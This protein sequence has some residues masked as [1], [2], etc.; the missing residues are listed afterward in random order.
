MHIQTKLLQKKFKNIFDNI[1]D[2]YVQI[3][4]DAFIDHMWWWWILFPEWK[5]ISPYYE[6]AYIIAS[7][8]IFDNHWFK[9]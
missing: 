2:E 6:W 9:I 8:E 7:K 1:S 4:R 5:S 3:V